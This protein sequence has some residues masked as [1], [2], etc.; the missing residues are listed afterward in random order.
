MNLSDENHF[1]HRHYN[2]VHVSDVPNVSE[3][4]TLVTT[5]RNVAYNAISV[6]LAPFYCIGLL[7]QMIFIL[8]FRLLMTGLYL[9][10][11]RRFPQAHNVNV[12]N[13]SGIHVTRNLNSVPLQ[14]QLENRDHSKLIVC[15]N[16]NHLHYSSTFCECTN[17]ATNEPRLYE[18]YKYHKTEAQLLM[19]PC[20]DC[21]YQRPK[22]EICDHCILVSQKIHLQAKTHQDIEIRTRPN[23]V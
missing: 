23:R 21:K 16:C 5:V 7:I 19:C 12:P 8:I 14:E 2:K 13:Q 22:P 17:C 18:C 15:P 9:L 6:A 1:N 3:P 10:L 20:I 11:F 4:A